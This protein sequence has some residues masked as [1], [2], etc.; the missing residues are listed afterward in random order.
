LSDK[1]DV[2]ARVLQRNSLA[3]TL[4]HDLALELSDHHQLWHSV[5]DGGFS[6]WVCENAGAAKILLMILRGD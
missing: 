4:Q 1:L 3:L 6:P 2:T 5:R